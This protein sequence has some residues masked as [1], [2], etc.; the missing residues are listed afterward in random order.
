M[1]QANVSLLYHTM[2]EGSLHS[3]GT[4]LFSSVLGNREREEERTLA[5]SFCCQAFPT[6]PYSVLHRASTLV[7]QKRQWHNMRALE[8]A[9]DKHLPAYL[10]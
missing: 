9:V 6:V 5:L 2:T 4:S 10:S 1:G 3:I 7:E 8:I